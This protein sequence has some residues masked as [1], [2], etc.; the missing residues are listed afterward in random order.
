MRVG[1]S[2]IDKKEV[3]SV[4][5]FRYTI[6][7]NSYLKDIALFQFPMALTKLAHFTDAVFRA[8]NPKAKDKEKPFVI[9]VKNQSQKT[10]LVVAVMG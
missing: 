7:E 8:K 6:V 9:S 2:L 5:S 4:K 1:I 3:K 10:T